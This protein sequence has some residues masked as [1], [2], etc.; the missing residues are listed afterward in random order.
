MARLVGKFWYKTPWSP[1]K[2]PKIDKPHSVGI[3]KAFYINAA[4]LKIQGIHF[5]PF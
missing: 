2:R 1:R 3:L 5:L 4:L